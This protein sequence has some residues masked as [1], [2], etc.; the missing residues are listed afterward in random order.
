M[1]FKGGGVVG[2][3]RGFFRDFRSLFGL[4]FDGRGRGFFRDFRGLFGLV[5]GCVYSKS[6]WGRFFLDILGWGG[7]VIWIFLFFVVGG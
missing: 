5:F 4:V 2:R 3:G 1:I 6:F 7:L